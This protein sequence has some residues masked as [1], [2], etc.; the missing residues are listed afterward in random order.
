MEGFTIYRLPVVFEFLTDFIL[1]LNIRSTLE[2]IKPD[3]VHI[4]EPVQGASALAAPHKELGF[5]LVVDQHGYATTFDYSETL[6]NKMA[7]QLFM[8]LRRPMG[9]YAFS[10][11][12][13][14]S[15]INERSKKFL[16]GI[17]NIPKDKI[18]VVPNGTDSD[19]FKFNMKL[20]NQIRKDLDIAPETIFI[21]SAGRV[22]PAKK[23]E[24][25]IYAFQK[26]IKKVNAKL[27]LIGSGDEEYNLKL[28]D[29]VEELGLQDRI[30]FIRFVNKKLLPGY[31]SA[32][33]IGFW[34]KEA[35][36]I[37]EAM[38][39]SLPVILPD[40]PTV[41]QY[42][43]NKNGLFFPDGDV[44]AL[45]E[46]LLEL[47]NNKELRSEMGARAVELVEEKFSYNVTTKRFLEIYKRILEN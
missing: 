45:Y 39:T 13:A 4:H 16:S 1:L 23:L 44:S 35:I 36:T 37:I 41:K 22:D 40:Q 29:L 20:R 18:E 2:K 38:S 8:L 15:A 3:I 42:I 21:I 28:Q 46:R 14:I 11:A 12:D 7:H 31:F 30:S 34:N 17:L 25:L 43:T 9:R 33:D 5:K 47:S 27:L 19:L 24:I 26:L 10:R 32:A 6:K